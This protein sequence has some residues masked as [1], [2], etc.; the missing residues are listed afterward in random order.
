MKE[1]IKNHCGKI[2]IA[3]III[4]ILYWY[5]VVYKPAQAKESTYTR[6]NDKNFPGLVSKSNM[7]RDTGNDIADIQLIRMAQQNPK[8]GATIES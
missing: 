8:L 6:Y 7:P 3:V 2:L 4:A 5:F 1:I